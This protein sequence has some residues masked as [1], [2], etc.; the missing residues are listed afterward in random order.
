MR[1]ALLRGARCQEA[2]FGCCQLD[3]ADFRKANLEGAN[4]DGVESIKGADFSQAEGLDALRSG[5]LSRDYNE[6]DCWNPL[7]RCTTRGSLES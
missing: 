1:F 7:S 5:L 6:L 3:F 4:F 2:R